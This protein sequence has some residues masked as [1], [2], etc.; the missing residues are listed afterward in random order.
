MPSCSSTV[1]IGGNI[2][3]LNGRNGELLFGLLILGRV[4][5]SHGP[6][7]VSKEIWFWIQDASKGA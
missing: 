6:L 1:S 5:V 7:L 4:E 2:P 3:D